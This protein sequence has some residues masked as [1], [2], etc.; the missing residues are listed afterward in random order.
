[1]GSGQPLRASSLPS[2][3]DLPKLTDGSSCPAWPSYPFLDLPPT[4]NHE[5]PGPLL[6]CSFSPACLPPRFLGPLLLAQGSLAL[7]F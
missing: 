6:R 4:A 3:M 5:L 2:P 7:S 1:M